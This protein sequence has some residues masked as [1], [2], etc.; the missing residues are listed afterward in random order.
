MKRRDGN[1]PATMDVGMI[2][3]GV[4]AE[5]PSLVIAMPM[6]DKPTV[7]SEIALRLNTEPH[8][9]LTVTGLPVD[10]ARN[11]L[12]KRILH[13]RP[14]PEIVVLL[15]DDAWWPPGAVEAL[16]DV[17]HGLPQQVGMLAA[18][19]CKRLP[20]APAVA[21]LKA[22]SR[23]ASLP[24]MRDTVPDGA[25]LRIE[26]C[27]LH[28]CALRVSALAALTADPFALGLATGEDIAFCV[29][30]RELFEIACAPSI[31]FAHIEAQTG[32]AYVPFGCPMEIVDNRATPL[33][34]EQFLDRLRSAGVPVTTV[35]T[36]NGICTVRIDN[37]LD[38]SYGSILD[39]RR[40]T[41]AA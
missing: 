12:A 22:D 21:Y 23:G 2:E 6:R 16:V 37:E 11:E 34:P 24:L 1:G 39:E 32:V 7:E 31:T 40:K 13:L 38:R 8:T 27:G 35:S 17:L 3:C 10:E 9:L 26:A 28:A 20:H 33:Q 36:A 41:R 25:I 30:L 18:G 14:L 19:F 29:R 5:Q 15:D 4:V